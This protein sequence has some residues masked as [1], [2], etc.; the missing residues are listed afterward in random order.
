MKIQASAHACSGELAKADVTTTPIFNLN[1][2]TS[3]PGELHPPHHCTS[4]HP[5][6]HF[7]FLKRGAAL[8]VPYLI[9]LLTYKSL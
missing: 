6:H 8:F 5:S 1:V 7:T 3:C 9:S 4:L 2:P